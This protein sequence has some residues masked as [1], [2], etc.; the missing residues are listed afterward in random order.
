MKTTETKQNIIS[1]SKTYHD[2]VEVYVQFFWKLT[3]VALIPNIITAMC[4]AAMFGSVAYSANTLEKASDLLA[5]DNG[6]S[7]TALLLIICI[8]LTQAIGV[9]A[10]AYMAV[11]HEKCSIKTAFKHSWEYLGRFVALAFAV[12]G[13]VIFGLLFGYLILM[14]VGI[15]VGA[16][17]LDLISPVYQWLNLIPQLISAGATTTII[18]AAYSIVDLNNET[19]AA[20]KHSFSLVRNHFWGVA[21]RVLLLYVVLQIVMYGLLFIPVIG[22][23]IALLILTPFTVVY[24]YV[25]YKNLKSVHSA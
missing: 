22:N 21:L 18:F 1:I 6:Y 20:M 16:L 5:F 15:I 3:G 7:W 24:L 19:R 2:S 10:L 4:I 8:I 12:M 25:L 17:S 23:L 9:V 13:L 11:H 14:F